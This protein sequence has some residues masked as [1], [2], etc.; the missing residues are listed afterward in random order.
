MEYLKKLYKKYHIFFNGNNG[1]GNNGNIMTRNQTVR[2][3]NLTVWFLVMI[4][5]LFFWSIKEFISKISLISILFRKYAE[6]LFIIGKSFKANFQ[7]H[8]RKS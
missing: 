6:V 5:L 1:N 7:T 3:I 2:S 4:F 8:S